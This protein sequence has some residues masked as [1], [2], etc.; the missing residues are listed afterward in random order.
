[1]SRNY[2]TAPILPDLVEAD[3]VY[4]P[5]FPDKKESEFN[6]NFFTRSRNVLAGLLP[7]F[8]EFEKIIKVIDVPAEHKGAYVHVVADAHSRKAVCYLK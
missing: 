4:I 3:I 6:N 8:K 5:V 7:D 2:P 1:M